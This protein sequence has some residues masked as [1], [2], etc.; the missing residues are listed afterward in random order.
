MVDATKSSGMSREAETSGRITLVLIAFGVA[1]LLTVFDI[2]DGRFYYRDIDDLLRSLQIRTLLDGGGW[3]DLTIPAIR[4]PEVYLSPWSRLVDLPYVVLTLLTQPFLGRE[5]ALAFAF[6]VWQPVMLAGFCWLTVA[7][8]QRIAGEAG[9]V[10][11]VH[12]IAAFAMMPLSLWE[13]SPGRIDHHNMQLLLLMLALYGVSLWSAVGGVLA[14][15]ACVLSVAVGLEL[16]PVVLIV[17]LGVGAAWVFGVAGSGP[18]QRAVTA[19]VAVLTPAAALL[20]IGPGEMLVTR[21][22]AFSAPYLAALTSYGAI[23]FAA[24]HFVRDARPVVRLGAVAVP[25]GLLAL[26]LAFAFPSCLHGPYQMIDTQLHALWLDR[27]QQE[28]TFLDFYVA[29]ETIKVVCLG[30]MAIVAAGALPV[31]WR[32]SRRGEVAVATVYAVAVAL[33]LFTLLQTRFIRFPG[34]CVMLF[35]PVV[36][37]EIGRRN[38]AVAR[39]TAAATLVVLVGGYGLYRLVPAEPFRPDVVD[40]LTFDTCTGVDVSELAGLPPGRIMAPSSLGLD[41]AGRLPEGMSVGAI[42]FHRAVPGLKR[43]FDLFVSTEGA[44]RRQAAEPFDYVAVCRYPIVGY[45]PNDTLYAKLAR[46]GEWPGLVRIVDSP[47]DGF[48]LFRIDHRALR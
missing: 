25:G 15:F 10:R 42:S 14:G 47:K 18:V 35:L 2:M 44:V 3:Y 7:T 11:P 30:L 38:I 9:L 24:T 8:M 41:I 31:V 19:S 48:Q 46:G 28:K 21:C 29:G 37:S 32:C 22:D 16:A 23:S 4:M 40:Y 6:H 12:V 33:F 39:A 45:I 17:M 1:V 13:F 43:M 27:V 20:L 36:W 5:R 34:A 26:L